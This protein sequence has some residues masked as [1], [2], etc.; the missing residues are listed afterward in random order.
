MKHFHKKFGWFTVSGF[1]RKEPWGQRHVNLALGYK[2]ISVSF[3][4]MKI[5]VD[6]QGY[7]VVQ[8]QP[9]A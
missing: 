5:P 7:V 6:E 9:A 3:G 4:A 2:G 1:Y 8:E